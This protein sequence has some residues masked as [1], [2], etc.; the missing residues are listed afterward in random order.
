MSTR[1]VVLLATLAVTVLLVNSAFAA[2][3]NFTSQ[4]L[5][6][7]RTCVLSGAPATTP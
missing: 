4:R 5:T 7:Y 6:P 2:S 1:V 3:L